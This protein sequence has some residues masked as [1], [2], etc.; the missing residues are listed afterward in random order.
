MK[1]VRYHGDGELR[2]E[3]IPDPTPGPDDVLL[4]PLAV[5]VCGTDNHIIAGHFVSRPPVV[6]GHEV[7]AEVIALGRDVR[8]LEVGQLITVEPHLYC[9][10]CVP[11]QTGRQHLCPDRAAPGVHLDGG[12]AG[13]LVVPATLAY[14]VPDG[15]PV[16][17][18]AMTEP[19]AC[20]VHGMDRLAPMSGM[21]LAVF[22]CGP[23]GAIM[24]ALARLAGAHPIIA[25]DPQP[26]RRQLALRVG[27]DVALD[28][29]EEGLTE[30]M[31]DLTDGQGVAAAIDAVGSARVL[32]QAIGLSARGGRILVFGVA[33]AGERAAI[34][35]NDVY[36]RELTILGTAL[37]P[38]TH[39]RAVG[40]LQRLPLDQL[41]T[42]SYDLDS[43]PDALD[44]QR[45]GKADKVFIHPQS[46][47]GGH[48]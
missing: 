6:L 31:A 20:C 15:V 42:A 21:P 4:A 43:V 19:I 7:A 11:C 5:G 10:R 38:Y 27:A 41:C 16:E 25:L 12:M 35:P 28:P 46:H 13:R 34:S 48:P 44:A 14:P 24:I 32:E 17:H 37:N 30:R 45:L 1:A 22:G 36:L 3:Q 23:A 18:A 2:V 33:D 26:A 9:G 47:N 29:T 40:L 39:R 8:G